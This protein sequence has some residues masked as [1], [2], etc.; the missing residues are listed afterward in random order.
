MCDNISKRFDVSLTQRVRNKFSVEYYTGFVKCS[1]EH[2]LEKNKD[3]LPAASTELL[4][5][6]DFE[7]IGTL[8]VSSL[9]SMVSNYY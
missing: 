6:S 8:K 3:Q 5:S 2:W 4:G 7:L 9:K 1:T